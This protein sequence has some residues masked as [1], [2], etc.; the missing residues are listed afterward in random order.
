MALWPA[1]TLGLGLALLQPVKGAIVALQWA[2]GMHGF[3]EAKI[4][5]EA[6]TR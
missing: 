4:R 6:R 5:R 1:F 2:L 3:E